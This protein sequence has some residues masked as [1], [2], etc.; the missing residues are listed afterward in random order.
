M[1][2]LAPPEGLSLEDY[3]AIED[4][5]METARGRWF[6]AE[7]AR[8]QRMAETHRLADAIDRL[9]T[10]MAGQMRAIAG[11]VA[12]PAA[13]P[14]QTAETIAE[15]LADMSWNLRE[16]GFEDR[17]CREIDDM[18]RMV[19]RMRMDAARDALQL[20]PPQDDARSA[21]EAQDPTPTMAQVVADLD[22]DAF[23][24]DAPTEFEMS[25]MHAPAPDVDF[26]EID[27]DSVRAPHATMAALPEEPAPAAIERPAAFTALE[28]RLAS[29]AA[30]AAVAPL[31][32]PAPVEPPPTF[33]RPARVEGDVIVA[34]P[35]EAPAAA[36]A[37]EEDYA[38]PSL[39]FARLDALPLR[40]K[41]ALFC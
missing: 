4:A 8:R 37:P 17:L 24:E 11:P 38:A 31:R 20:A 14:D 10:M 12:A 27:L 40:E 35:V 21:Q 22:D 30:P 1:T 13:A 23:S 2:L 6:L 5:V 26:V 9:E 34:A 29:F 19:R 15:R 32:E 39:A 7:F 41:L 33:F 36:P 3:A 25:E 16:R 18:A 28:E